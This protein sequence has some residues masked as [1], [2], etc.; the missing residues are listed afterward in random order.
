MKYLF[1]LSKEHRKIPTTE[2]TTL[3]QTE[4]I[5]HEIIESTSD[6]LIINSN[7]GKKILTIAERLAYTYFLDEL[8]FTST[9]DI[10]S[11]K[12]KAEENKIKQL[13]TIAVKYR[14][15]SEKINS[16]EIIKAIADVYTEEREVDLDDTEIEIRL[17]ISDEKIYVT[18]K[19]LKINRIQYEQRKVQNRPF[20]S[21]I[22]LHPKLARYLVNIS[23]IRKGQTLLDP[24]V[25][26]GG[27]I[28][29]AGLIGVNVIGSD[30]EQKMIQGC[31]KTLDYY[32]V[33]HYDLF[34]SDIGEID[35]KIPKKIDAVVT[36]MP[37]GKATTTKGE[38]M[39][40]LYDRTFKKI[41]EILKNKSKAVIGL[42]NKKHIKQAEKYLKLNSLNEI[43][44]HG[45]LTRYFPVFEKQP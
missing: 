33:K 3:L 29:E 10:K 43:R 11:L 36:D 1:E 42:S 35:K 4:Q 2:I 26:T 32:K 17:I 5:E 6:V 22:S 13:G 37:Y 41:S 21:P 44:V 7:N 23:G 8:L 18:I 24:F 15:R 12:K 38:D 40:I 30:V 20:F 34:C 28:L 16:R 39:D 25:G 27:M 45:S 19:K 14:N 31:K 9:I